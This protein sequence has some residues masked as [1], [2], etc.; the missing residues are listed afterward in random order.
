MDRRDL[1]AGYLSLRYHQIDQEVMGALYLDARSRLIEERELCRGT[2][3]R[4]AVEPRTILKPAF[5]CGA[6]GLILF[7]THPSGDPAPS[8]D[9][10]NFTRRLQDAAEISGLVL[11]DHLILGTE[12]RFVTLAARD[13]WPEPE[14]R[15]ILPET[16]NSNPG[17]PAG[18][19]G[20]RRPC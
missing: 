7:H 5:L 20:G 19:E 6:H 16:Q 15:R 8:A 2:I 18:Q 10:L 4:T 11:Y 1:V 13:G 14:R 3:T 17:R 12:G 9:D